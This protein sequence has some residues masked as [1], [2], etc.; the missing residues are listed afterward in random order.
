MPRSVLLVTQY[1]PPSSLV[2]A[3]RVA[4]LAKYLGRAGHAVT[5]L[6]SEASG[7]GPIEGAETVVRTKDAL[8]SKLNWRRRHFAAL[9][10]GSGESYRPPSRLAS[11]VVP[12]LSLLTWLPFA[13]PAALRLAQARS[14]DC[15]LT[16]SPP[17]SV[18]LIGRALRRRG[19]PWIAELRDG[20]G[21]EPPHP[22]WPLAAQ[23]RLD[24][25]LER[26]VLAGADAVIGV[27]EP[28]AADLR[29][30]YG[31]DA[32]VITNG[33]DPDDEPAETAEPD[34]LL[35]PDRHS[36]VHT[37]RLA[38][39]GVSLE[40]VLEGARLARAED[41]AVASGLEIVFAGSATADEQRLLAASDLAELVRFVGWLDRPR[42]LALQ[43]AADALLVVTEGSGRRSV[44]TGKLF[45]YLAAG[46]PIL[47]LGDET[48]AAR[49]VTEAGAGFAASVSDPAAVAAALERLLRDPPGP[50][51][52]EAIRK[53]SY[54]VLAGRV[55]A[56][57]ERVTGG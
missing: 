3:R 12:D 39:S 5:V 45:E 18:H 56:A 42:V 19:V 29:R 36:L 30:R 9:A 55:A 20:W 1:A 2:A 38:L 8:T 15:V 4:A 57:I 46:R 35:A 40:R 24:H 54:A 43:R 52:A 28:I 50:A 21:F 25:G 16:T 41:P 49:L 34:P 14:F 51:S 7:E 27:T 13:L 37:G 32:E 6:T 22:S 23:E 53:Y 48:E 31:I 44:A 33:Y 17:P 26:W 10:G 11:V 47:V